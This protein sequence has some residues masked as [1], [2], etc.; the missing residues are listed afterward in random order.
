M[1]LPY[2]LQKACFKECQNLAQNSNKNLKSV[3][4]KLSLKSLS[5]IDTFWSKF[6]L[7][8]INVV[9]LY[10]KNINSLYISNLSWK[11][12]YE[13]RRI[14][15]LQRRYKEDVIIIAEAQTDSALHSKERNLH[16]NFLR[17]DVNQKIFYKKANELIDMH[18]QDRVL[19]SIKGEITKF[20]AMS[21]SDPTNLYRR[22]QNDIKSNEKQV[23]SITTYDF[24]NKQSDSSLNI[25]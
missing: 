15:R 21:G 20:C 19:R 17:L 3:N 6:S 22:T 13:Y 9:H 10:F 12:S 16:N 5:V 1:L 11:K 24:V 8:S 2:L 18:Q 4:L 23:R 7:K 14:M 25:I